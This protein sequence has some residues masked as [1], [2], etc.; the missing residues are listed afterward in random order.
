[1][2]LIYGRMISDFVASSKIK[3][4]EIGLTVPRRMLKITGYHFQIDSP[5][6]ERFPERIELH[7]WH[8]GNK[9]K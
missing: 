4:I 7:S 2:K 1:M 6:V 8:H 9:Q 3:I 5:R